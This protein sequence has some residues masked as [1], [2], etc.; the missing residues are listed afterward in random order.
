MNTNERTHK[1]LVASWV[2]IIGNAILAVFKIVIGLFSGSLSVFG[3][4]I[5]SASDVATYIVTLFAAKIIARPADQRFPYGYNR[6]ET[7][8][9]TILAFVIM[10]VGVQLLISSVE[11]LAMDEARPLPHISAAIVTVASIFG[12]FFLAR[13]QLRRGK[14]TESSMLIANAYNMRFDIFISLAVL[15]GLFF[16]YVLKT[17]IL[18]SIV[19]IGVS[20]WIIFTAIKILRD[21]NT[22]LMDGVENTDIYYRI[23]SSVESV[24]GAHNPHRIRVRKNSRLYIIGLDIEVDPSMTVEKS[25]LICQEIEVNLR[26]KI[27]NIFDIVIHV[28]P[29]GIHHGDDEPYGVHPGNVD[30]KAPENKEIK[31]WKMRGLH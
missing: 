31:K 22:E 5:D 25:H 30:E 11:R 13:W 28:E 23:F 14:E 29:L 20:M 9:T 26:K 10:F 18:D 12:K 3:D 4:G 2:G 8:A 1:I 7:I 16:T 27:D 15:V 21:T 24:E 19:A 6:A 17:P